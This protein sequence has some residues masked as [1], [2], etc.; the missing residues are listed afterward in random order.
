[1]AFESVREALTALRAAY[2]ALADCDV[3]TLT[4]TELLEVLDE[5]QTIGCQLPSQNHR[6]LARLQAESTPRELGAKSWRDV[7]AIRWR[8]S[9]EEANRRLTETALL[10]PRRA[11]TGAPLPPLLVATATAQR[12]GLITPEHVTVI[13]LAM[14]RMPGWVDTATRERLEVDWVRH[15]VGS[16]PK[17]LQDQ[18]AR[19]LFLLDQDGPAPDDEERARRRGLSKGRQQHDAMTEMKAN[20]TPEAWAVWEVLFARYAAPGMCNPADVAPCTSGTPTQA[21]IDGDNR[22]IEQR[23]HDAFEFIGRAAF[24]KGELGQLNGLPTAI[25]VRTT[26]QELRTLAGIGITGGGTA[27]PIADV[28]RMAA[29][30]N[31]TNYLAVFDDATG[32]TLDLFRTRRTASVAQRFALIA[33]DGGCTKPGCTV[34]AYGAQVHHAAKDWTA[35][36]DT[37]IDDLGLACGPDNRAVGPGGWT[38]LLNHRHEVEWIPPAGLDTGQKRTNGYHHPEKLLL[39]LEEDDARP[40][41]EDE[42]GRP[43]PP[44]NTA[45]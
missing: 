26:L 40:A 22:S 27:L 24:D 42:P 23:R 44:G 12:L 33:R 8:I 39:P 10:A 20:L 1:M 36:G 30:A 34:P 17:E 18:T 3:E 14:K 28:L 32:S 11:L 2:D 5:V 21:Q 37:N 15:A 29:H 43:E 9:T 45:A 13:R 25:I 7:I 6:L 16:G 19:T 35:G 31:A 4:R 41:A 38:T